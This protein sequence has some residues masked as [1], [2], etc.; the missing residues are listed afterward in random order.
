V[1]VNCAVELSGIVVKTKSDSVKSDDVSDSVNNREVLESL[2]VDNNSG[3]VV[4]ASLGTSSVEGRVNNLEGADVGTLVGFVW[5]SCIDN[6]TVNMVSISGGKANLV[7][8]SV[9]VLLSGDLSF[10]SDLLF[11]W[12]SFLCSSLSWH[13]V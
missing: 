7:E 12:G 11:G 2:G 1:L 4:V 13:F 8:V 10:G 6:N 3:E 5:E 9:R